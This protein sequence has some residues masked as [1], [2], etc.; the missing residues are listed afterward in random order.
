MIQVIVQVNLVHLRI[1][2]WCNKGNNIIML[3]TK[4][5]CKKF[6]KINSLYLGQLVAVGAEVEM[7]DAELKIKLR[8]ISKQAD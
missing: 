7:R 5:I 8:K 2:K 4:T 3:L 1:R 6:P